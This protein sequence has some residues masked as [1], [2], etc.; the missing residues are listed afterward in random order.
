L[1]ITDYR[2]SQYPSLFWDDRSSDI[3][4][5]SILPLLNSEEMGMTMSEVV[6]R[7]EETDY[8]P[9]LFGKAYGVNEITDDKIAE[10]L[11]QFL[12]SISSY[13]SKYDEGLDNTFEDFTDSELNGMNIFKTHCD[14]CHSD[15][16]HYR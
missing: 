1:N 7:M 12:V 8:Y 3:R 10:A 15:I 13:E 2:T 6:N 5:A 11:S 16:V 9:D 14:N 4:E